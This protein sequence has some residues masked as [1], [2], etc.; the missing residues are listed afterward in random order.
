MNNITGVFIINLALLLSLS[1]IIVSNHFTIKRK[2]T[3]IDDLL[4]VGREALDIIK[5]RNKTIEDQQKYLNESRGD[6]RECLTGD[7]N[8][9]QNGDRLWFGKPES[10]TTK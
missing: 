2:E 3:Q 8:A 5:D 7:R 4:R 9:P 10:T 1:S 6:L